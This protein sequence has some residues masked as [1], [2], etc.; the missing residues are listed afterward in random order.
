[1]MPV[2]S[3]KTSVSRIALTISFGMYFSIFSGGS[4]ADRVDEQVDGL[5]SGEG[6]DDAADS[7]GGEV[8]PDQGS[9][10]DRAVAHAAQGERD[11]DDDDDGVE[12]HGRQHGA[13]GAVQLHDVESVQLR[14][15][16]K[17]DGGD[18]REI[19]RDIVGDAE[20]GQRATR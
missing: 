14:Q 20:R 15:R 17:E 3:P 12:D 19:L 8:V 2:T 16:D 10:T 18:D 4:Q 9:R 13:V 1:M 5:D 7:V 11:E 6:G